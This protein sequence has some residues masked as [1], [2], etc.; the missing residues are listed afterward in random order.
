LVLNLRQFLI[1]D[2]ELIPSAYHME[3]QKP[4]YLSYYI[5]HALYVEEGAVF[6]KPIFDP[7]I[8]HT[9]PD[10]KPNCINHI[11]LY[12]GS[13]NPSHLGHVALLNHG[14]SAGHDLNIIAAIIVPLDDKSLDRKLSQQDGALPKP[15]VSGYGKEFLHQVTIIGHL[16]E[17]CQNGIVFRDISLRVCYVTG[18][19]SDGSC[20]VALIML[21]LITHP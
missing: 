8:C 1:M 15:N 6:Q 4:S 14:M 13:F 5:E 3:H 21:N 2:E 9:P 17:I 10:L 20:S 7:G 12:P 18:L 19:T 16:I 11:L